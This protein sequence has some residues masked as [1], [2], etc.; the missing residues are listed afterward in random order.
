MGEA[1]VTFSLSDFFFGFSVLF[2]FFSGGD[3]DFCSF[4]FNV[5]APFTP[6]SSLTA[7]TNKLSFEK[8]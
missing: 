5:C 8:L 7:A 3:F 1:R 4:C 6:T 2:Y